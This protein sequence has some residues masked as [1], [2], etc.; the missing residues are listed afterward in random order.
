MDHCQKEA[1]EI[2]KLRASLLAKEDL[3]KELNHRF[4]NYLQAISYL[5]SSQIACV[6]ETAAK[7]AITMAVSRI[8]TVALIQDM[9]SSVEQGDVISVR[10]YLGQLTTYLYDLY[11]VAHTITYTLDIDDI[12]L[13]TEKMVLLGLILNEL[14]SNIFKYAFLGLGKG[15]VLLSL[16]ESQQDVVLEVSD[17]G[18]GL[19]PRFKMPED[20]HS[21]LGIVQGLSEQLG[22]VLSISGQSGT[23]CTISW[24]K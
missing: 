17:D 21:G 4:K 22:G 8:R 1:T 7:D 12:A 15:R 23:T 18:I 10:D 20:R 6:A 3:I 14:L 24:K 13:A 16:K 5:L 2:D 19:P 9:F 11:G